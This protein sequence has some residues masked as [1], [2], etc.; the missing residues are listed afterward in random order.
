[1]SDPIGWAPSEWASIL[2]ERRS[3]GGALIDAIGDVHRAAFDAVDPWDVGCANAARAIGEGAY[4]MLYGD[5]PEADGGPAWARATV[6]AIKALDGLQDAR[7]AV[8]GDPDM[9]AIACTALMRAVADRIPQIVEGL[10]EAGLDPVTGQPLGGEEADPA[11]LAAFVSEIGAAAGRGRSV[12]S[13]VVEAVADAREAL[14]GILPGM[15]AAPPR[16][17]QENPGRLALV[18]RIRKDKRLR[19]VLEVAGRMQRIAERVRMQRTE[20][21]PEEVVDVERG[22]EIGRILPSEL[23]GL[24]HPVRRRLVLKG[25]AERGLLQYRLTGTERVGRGPI[26]VLLDVSSSMSY[27][28]SGGLRRVDWAAA[29]GIATVRSAV[30]QKRQVSVATFNYDV[31]KTWKIPA[32]DTSAARDAVLE[33]AQIAP[34]GGTSFDAPIAWALDAGAERDKADLVLVTDGYGAIGEMVGARL[35][36]AKSRGLRLWGVLAGEGGLGDS[37]ADHA[38]GIATLDGTT[39]AAQAIGSMGAT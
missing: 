36:D 35:A 11:E 39:D 16:S 17:E 21:V 19:K 7:D 5:P 22:G 33:I 27:P 2:F 8:A 20:D 23:A 30:L 1:M 29:V 24:R 32:G 10:R 37:I 34:Y 31:A 18:D 28:L 13:E 14:N 9:S 6:E 25:I 3:R 38:D 15:G 4:A 26:A 12:A